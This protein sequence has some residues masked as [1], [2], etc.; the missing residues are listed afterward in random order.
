[1]ES[2]AGSTR[3]LLDERKAAY[4][5]K[6]QHGTRENVERY[7]WA[8]KQQNTVFKQKKRQLEDRDRDEME[9]LFRQNETRKFYERLTGPAKASRRKPILV[10]M[11]RETYSWTK[12]RS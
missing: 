5:R 3:Q 6:L 8:K 2:S 12:A 11:P 9:Q 4:A 7:K 1:M 10:G